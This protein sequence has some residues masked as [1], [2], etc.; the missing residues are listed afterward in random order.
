MENYLWSTQPDIPTKPNYTT[1]EGHHETI[2]KTKDRGSEFGFN[3]VLF[4]I[5]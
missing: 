1:P 4:E 2:I 3:P 5:K